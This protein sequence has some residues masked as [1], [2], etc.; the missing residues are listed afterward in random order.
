MKP[1]APALSAKAVVIDFCDFFFLFPVKLKR[2]KAFC[3]LFIFNE[4]MLEEKYRKIVKMY[5]YEYAP[6]A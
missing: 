4:N 3:Y 5:S 1:R 2:G 6:G